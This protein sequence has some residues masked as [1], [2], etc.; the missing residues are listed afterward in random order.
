MQCQRPGIWQLSSAIKVSIFNMEPNPVT[1]HTNSKTGRWRAI[2]FAG[3]LV[4]TLDMLAAV[5]VYQANPGQIFKFIASGAFGAGRAFGG[6]P[7]M[8]VW[9]IAFHYAIAFAW[10]IAFFLVY[11]WF[12]MLWR[13]KYIT[14]SL[15]GIFIWS[16]M[17][18]IVIPLSAIPANPFNLTSATIAASI[19]IVAVG[20]PIAF[21]AHRYY[22]RNGVLP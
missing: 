14:G 2:I 21:L 8:V 9:G 17:N 7:I 22:S 15:Y 10:T 5:T 19:L 12:P 20:L 4:G 16:I 3:L 18:L 13:N 1:Y 6:G 11:P